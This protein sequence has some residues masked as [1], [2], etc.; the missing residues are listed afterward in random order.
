MGFFGLFN[1]NAYV[2]RVDLLWLTPAVKLKGTLAYLDSTMTDLC[3]AW[4]E[5]TYQAFTRYLN[6]EHRMNMDIRI[7]DSIT[8]NEIRNRKVVFLEHY[9][10]YTKETKLISG[11][12]PASIAFMNSLEDVLFCIF[13]GN[14]ENVMRSLGL[15]EN[16]FVENA[17]ISKSIIRAQRRLE[18]GIRNEF[19]ARSAAEWLSWYRITGKGNRL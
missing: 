18:K 3:V 14:M 2:A 13:G 11:C 7:A 4:F 8:Q 19:N 6:E 9:P 17:M 12:N 1:K 5:E 16:D 10:L 15:G